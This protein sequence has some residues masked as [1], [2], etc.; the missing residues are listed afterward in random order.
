MK[1]EYCRRSTISILSVFLIFLA[2]GPGAAGS[3]AG[4]KGDSRYP[5][6]FPPYARGDCYKAYK[7]YVAAPGHSAYASTLVGETTEGIICGAY[8]DAASQT[9]AETQALKSCQ[10]AIK[11]YKVGASGQCSV[12]ASK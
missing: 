1:L 8:L 5:V 2:P 10:S 9:A 3:L 11:K 6:Y 4:S 12:A 7:A